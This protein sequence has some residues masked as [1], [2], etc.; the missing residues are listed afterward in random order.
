MQAKTKP[1]TKRSAT[2]RVACLLLLA[3]AGCSS[4]PADEQPAPSPM[5]RGGETP[6]RC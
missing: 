4:K 1:I 6:I 3:A 2:W 5:A